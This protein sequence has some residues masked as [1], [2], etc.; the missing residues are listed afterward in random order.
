MSVAQKNDAQL[1]IEYAKEEYKVAVFKHREEAAIKTRKRSPLRFEE[2]V[3]RRK[4]CWHP[5]S[6][7]QGANGNTKVTLKYQ[8]SKDGSNGHGRKE[9]HAQAKISPLNEK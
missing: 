3:G 6:Q 9:E 2:D 7:D 8:S 4:Q 1:A 5:S